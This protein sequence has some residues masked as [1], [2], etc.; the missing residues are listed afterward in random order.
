MPQKN[1]IRCEGDLIFDVEAGDGGPQTFYSERTG[2]P[3]SKGIAGDFV[4]RTGEQERGRIKADGSTTGVFSSSGGGGSG[5]P[6]TTKGDLWGFDTADNRIPIG[7]NG[8]S[9]IADSTKALGLKWGSPAADPLSAVLAAGSDAN[10]TRITNLGAPSAST[11]AATKGY[12]DSLPAESLAATLAAGHDANGVTINN[13]GAPSAQTDLATKAY[14]D[15]LTPNVQSG[16]TYT[17]AITD[18]GKVVVLTSATGCTL[19]IP[20]NATVAFPL[21]TE[22]RIRTGTGAG[23]LT[24]QGDGVS[25]VS[26]PFNVLTCANQGASM[27]LLKIGTDAWSL[28]GEVT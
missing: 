1:P 13:A 25:T 10:A 8:Q 15:V 23:T 9:L 14:V 19:T 26:N 21:W 12:A 11:D 18:M 22:I 20:R 6:L 17:L 27:A 7:T 4:V 3:F 24:V 28:N 16:T 5:S 2:T